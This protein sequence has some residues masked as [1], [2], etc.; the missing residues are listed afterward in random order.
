MKR[1]LEGAEGG[2][3]E[4]RRTRSKADKK[5]SGGGGSAGAGAGASA[6]SD[7]SLAAAFAASAAAAA[8]A[9]AEARGPCSSSSSSGVAGAGA[10]AGGGQR[11]ASGERAADVQGGG[12]HGE[13]SSVMRAV[14]AQRRVDEVKKKYERNLEY[15]NHSKSTEARKRL[16]T[17][18]TELD[19]REDEFEACSTA[20][21]SG[22][23]VPQLIREVVDRQNELERVKAERDHARQMLDA[24]KRAYLSTTPATGRVFVQTLMGSTI[25]LDALLGGPVLHLK[26]QLQDK[27]CIPV[28]QMRLIFG[29]RH[30]EDSGLLSDYGIMAGNTIDLLLLLRGD[31]GEF[32]HTPSLGREYLV[33]GTGAASPPASA[34]RNLVERLGGS[35]GTPPRVIEEEQLGARARSSLIA[36]VEQARSGEPAAGADF[37]LRL[38]LRELRELVDDSSAVDRLVE[39]LGQP[40][41][42]IWLRRTEAA[43]GQVIPWHRDVSLRTLQVPL[44]EPAEYDGGRLVF[45]C[46]SGEL[47]SPPRVAGSATLHDNS[48]IHGVTELPRGTRYALF[49]LDEKH[50]LS[51]GRGP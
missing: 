11:E 16:S 50:D 35:G 12:G 24:Y 41:C 27:E 21:R 1:E 30:L 20:L 36:R 32:E 43:A 25:T 26:S 40:S 31:I 46:A 19:G 18:I 17:A 42:K 45:A 34:V 7:N 44:N 22:D 49:L 29:G 39:L 33:A 4:A 23:G 38:E 5:G 47:L 37:K 13:E 10:G 28:D 2:E 6:S 14:K 3:G 9:A 8:L 51:R 48:V 15:A